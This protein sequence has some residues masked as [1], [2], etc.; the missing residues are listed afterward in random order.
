MQIPIYGYPKRTPG[1]WGGDFEIQAFSTAYQLKVAIYLGEVELW[2]T[3]KPL[4]QYSAE[5]PFIYLLLRSNHFEPITLLLTVQP[6]HETD[7]Q[8]CD[9]SGFRE[10]RCVVAETAPRVFLIKIPLP[11][12]VTNYLEAEGEFLTSEQMGVISTILCFACCRV[13]IVKYPLNLQNVESS[14][15][16]RRKFAP[17]QSC[18]DVNMCSLCFQYL[19]KEK[20]SGAELWELPGFL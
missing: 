19:T 10:V 3:M 20:C 7:N 15:T 6:A 2:V 11:S 18:A 8:I 16:K 1:V 5:I 14:K 12:V 4:I 13:S 17:L 9:G